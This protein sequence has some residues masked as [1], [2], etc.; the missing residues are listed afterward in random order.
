MKSVVFLGIKPFIMTSFSLL[1]LMKVGWLME[2]IGMAD[3]IGLACTNPSPGLKSWVNAC[4]FPPNYLSLPPNAPTPQNPDTRRQCWPNIA[5][6]R[7][8]Q[9]NLTPPAPLIA[10]NPTQGALPRQDI[11]S[12]TMSGFIDQ[13]HHFYLHLSQSK[14]H[15]TFQHT[16]VQYVV[17]FS[18]LAFVICT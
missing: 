9:T 2:C 4:N 18:G 12:K 16:V 3:R 14:K 10:L 1:N 5:L 6:R 15:K 13:I 11:R 17:W 8:L 7:P